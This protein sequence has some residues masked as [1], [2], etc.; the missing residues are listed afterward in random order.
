M[1]MKYQKIINFLGKTSNHPYKFRTKNQFEIDDDSRGT[2]K[3]NSQIIF[4]TLMSKSSLCGYTDA[5]ILVKGTIAVP[6]TAATGAASNNSNKK[7]TIKNCAPFT[8]CI[9]KI[10]NTQVHNAKNIDVV[11][12]MHMPQNIVRIIQN[13]VRIKSGSP[14]QYYRDE[15]ALNA[16]GDIID[17][18]DD[19][20]RK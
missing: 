17:F 6:N 5:Y 2:Y 14:W 12:P 13:I 3:T 18:P 9:R 4:N 20:N 19:N 15:P 10:S 16:A 7:I 8:D 1:K 11:M